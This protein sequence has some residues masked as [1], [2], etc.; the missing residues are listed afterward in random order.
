MKQK[1]YILEFV[2]DK[3]ELPESTCAFWKII[4]EKPNSP[5]FCDTSVYEFAVTSIAGRYQSYFSIIFKTINRF[6]QIAGHRIN[7]DVLIQLEND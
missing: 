6:T 5:S 4:F 2:F 7:E 3:M 1:K